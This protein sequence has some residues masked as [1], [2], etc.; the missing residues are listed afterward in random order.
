MGVSMGSHLLPETKTG[1]I[2]GVI[3][4]I[5]AVYGLF[6]FLEVGTVPQSIWEMNMRGFNPAAFLA[7]IAIVPLWLFVLSLF[8]MSFGKTENKIL[9]YLSGAVSFIA[10]LL[11][12]LAAFYS[13]AA[14]TQIEEL[15]L[16]YLILEDIE[17]LLLGI[18]LL[19]GGLLFLKIGFQTTEKKGLV[20]LTAIVYLAVGI[21]GLLVGL[22]TATAMFPLFDRTIYPLLAGAIIAPSVLTLLY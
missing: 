5:A 9:G 12:F 8:F 22:S 10:G 19:L 2:S 7:F 6:I 1:K 20:M 14:I 17:Y 15:W 16:N 4:I 18:S 21:F 11:G 13:A 3:G